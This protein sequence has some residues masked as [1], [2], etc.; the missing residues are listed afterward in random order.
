MSEQVK[1]R[2]FSSVGFRI[3]ATF[4]VMSVLGLFTVWVAWQGLGRINGRNQ[5]IVDYAT[6]LLVNAYKL[7]ESSAQMSVLASE[8]EGVVRREDLQNF[9][10]ELSQV[11][12][13]MEYE[14]LA[15]RGLGV[16]EDRVNQLSVYLKDLSS[17]LDRQLVLVRRRV[18]LDDQ[19]A[20]L[21]LQLSGAQQRLQGNLSALRVRSGIESGGSDR[22]LQAKID[23]VSGLVEQMGLNLSRTFLSLS[24]DEVMVYKSRFTLN[25]R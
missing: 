19:L 22:D 24:A 6:P 9:A 21:D 7:S 1:S 20:T 10:S 25:A 13:K 8:A 18:E 12:L 14:I 15:I 3:M 16:G 23:E 4:L 17:L 11:R 5:G 2:G